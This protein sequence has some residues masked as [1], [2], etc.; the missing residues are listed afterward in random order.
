MSE[1]QGTFCCPICGLD[2]PHAHKDDGVGL[3]RWYEERHPQRFIAH[4]KERG[5]LPSY[6]SDTWH[7]ADADGVIFIDPEI[8]KHWV[9]YQSAIRDERRTGE[10]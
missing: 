3:I 5:V 9:T 4:I 8:Q 2:T 10:G 1:P 7:P 6:L